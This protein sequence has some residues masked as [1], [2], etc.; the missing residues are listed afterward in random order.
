L[1]TIAGDGESSAPRQSRRRLKAHFGPLVTTGHHN[2]LDGG[3]TKSKLGQ[4]ARLEGRQT[5]RILVQS[6]TGRMNDVR[7]YV[8]GASS[9]RA[10]RHHRRDQ[11]C[12][13]S[14]QCL[15]YTDS[16]SAHGNFFRSF[17]AATVPD[18][19]NES[20]SDLVAV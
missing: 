19:F 6:R 5:L 1:L 4:R 11:D 7:A 16:A 8:L 10:K 20:A 15:A 9:A 18:H 12:P 14:H 3:V 2:S 17:C 13:T